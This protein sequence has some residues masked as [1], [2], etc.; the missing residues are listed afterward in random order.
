MAGRLWK[1]SGK[2]RPHH[3]T[4]DHCQDSFCNVKATHIF[5]Q[6][7]I[8][9]LP[10]FKIEI[11]KS[12]YLKLGKVLNNWAEINTCCNSKI[13]DLILFSLVMNSDV[14]CNPAYALL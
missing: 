1:L 5:Q 4:R 11:L 12:C 10:Y 2:D 7:N 9:V 8:N 14:K 6:K 13:A 3:H